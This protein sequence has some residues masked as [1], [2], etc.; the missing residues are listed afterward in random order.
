MLSGSKIRPQGMLLIE[1]AAIDL[2]FGFEFGGRARFRLLTSD[3]EVLVS[4]PLNLLKDCVG[5]GSCRNSDSTR[6]RTLRV[7]AFFS[8]CGSFLVYT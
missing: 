4:Q 5:L 8:L 2:E 6:I 7:E 3:N 1:L